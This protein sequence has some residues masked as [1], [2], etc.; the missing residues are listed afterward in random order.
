MIER[1]DLWIIRLRRSRLEGTSP[2]APSAAA[3]TRA[4]SRSGGSIMRQH[5][6]A[7]IAS[8]VYAAASVLAPAPSARAQAIPVAYQLDAPTTFVHRYCLAPCLCPYH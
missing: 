8:A 6:L 2:A 7:L 3:P 4:I 5:R 1:P